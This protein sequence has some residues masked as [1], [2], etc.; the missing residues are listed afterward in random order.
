MM[1]K[2]FFYI[3]TAV[4]VLCLS[5]NCFAAEGEF[6]AIYSENFESGS[7]PSNAE[8]GDNISVNVKNGELLLESASVFGFAVNDDGTTDFSGFS[9]PNFE[10]AKIRELSEPKEYNGIEYYYSY[11]SNEGYL[12]GEID[13]KKAQQILT[14]HNGSETSDPRRTNVLKL[15]PDDSFINSISGISDVTFDVELYANEEYGSNNMIYFAYT[16]TSGTTK[17][18]YISQADMLAAKE[19]NGGD[20]WVTVSK[21]LTDVDLTKPL[22][23]KTTYFG[24]QQYNIEISGGYQL[25]YS[26]YIRSFSI[27]K[28][29]DESSDSSLEYDKSAGT[30]SAVKLPVSTSSIFGD[31]MISFELKIPNDES[32][33]GDIMYNSGH[34]SFEAYVADADGKPMVRFE[35]DIDTARDIDKQASIYLTSAVNGDAYVNIPVAQVPLAA[36]AEPIAVEIITNREGKTYTASVSAGGSKQE[37]PGTLPLLNSADYADAQYVVFGIHPQSYAAC[38]AVD[39]ISASARMPQ[40]YVYC[41]DDTDSLTLPQI[42]SPVKGN[43]DLPS[44]GSM[45]GSQITWDTSNSDVISIDGFLAVVNGAENERTVTLTATITNGEFTRTKDFDITVAAFG[46]M[47]SNISDINSA[48]DVSNVDG[49]L[50]IKLTI[51]SPGTTQP[52]TFMAIASD[53]ATGAITDRKFD[54]K[55]ASSRFGSVNFEIIGLAAGSND[56]VNYYIWDENRVSLINLA[57]TDISNLIIT[58]K[59]GV[60]NIGWDESFDDN[61]AVIYNVYRDD[62]LIAETAENKYNDTAVE[63]HAKHEYKVVAYDTNG[64]GSNP[65]SDSAALAAVT[66]YWQAD[67]EDGEYTTVKWTHATSKDTSSMYSENATLGDVKCVMAPVKGVKPYYICFDLMA[68]HDIKQ[69]VECAAVVRVT[70]YDGNG[71]LN[72]R[73]MANNANKYKVLSENMTNSGTWKTK[74]YELSDVKLYAT[75][76]VWSNHNFI[77]YTDTDK[78]LYVSRV[79]VMTAEKFR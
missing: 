54:T 13:G 41:T 7:V 59:V 18:T 30:A 26:N 31:A 74:T 71:K 2:R 67:D 39:N 28:T 34:N 16:D 4:F 60:I 46:N 29:V 6:D 42:Q 79:E 33:L 10:N 70:Y 36:L 3:L 22:N 73:Y 5:V 72:L 44:I 19:A 11:G 43:F 57:P 27:H 21:S 77:F 37:I 17:Y 66:D 23:G 20:P 9:M 51:N 45:H 35:I 75:D 48:V 76:G 78:E 55:S 32:I 62:V 56:D 69:D 49:K 8:T 24:K 53:K 50:N 40:E 52:I 64:N 1:T 65:A 12:T 58:P 68:S 38:I 63:N 14:F 15:V 25:P 47:Y 61:G